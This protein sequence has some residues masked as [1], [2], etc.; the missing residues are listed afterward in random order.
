AETAPVEACEPNNLDTL[1]QAASEKQG[2]EKSLFDASSEEVQA[3][4]SAFES[5]VDQLYSEI[6][7]ADT[8][9]TRLSK[10]EPLLSELESVFR[11]RLQ[12]HIREGKSKEDIKKALREGLINQL[13]AQHEWNHFLVEHYREN[14]ILSE[15][16]SKKQEILSKKYIELANAG[17]EKGI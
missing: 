1:F 12:K 5:L 17:L 14:G 4:L 13:K 11:S 6:K 7:P 8:I 15:L 3:S 9:E 2:T 16:D 10:L